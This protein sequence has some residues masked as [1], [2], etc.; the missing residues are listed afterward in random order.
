MSAFFISIYRLFHN[1]KLLFYS[2]LFIFLGLMAF[3]ASR[4]RFEEDITKTMGKADD[5]DSTAFV[6]RNLKMADKL[7]IEVAF[8]D[9]AASPGPLKLIDHAT[10]LVDSLNRYFDSTIIKNILFQASENDILATMQ[11]V[12][13]H[14]PSFLNEKDYLKIDS[15]L[16]P[17]AINEAFAGN[18]RILTTPASMVLRSRIQQDPLGITS[19]AL[20]K[21]RS[22]QA[23][24]SYRIIDGCIFSQDLRH[25]LLFVVPACPSSETSKNTLLIAGIDKIIRSFPSPEE[26]GISIGYF[27]AAA[28]SV[29][30]ANQL[31]KD[32]AL[33]LTLS[34]LLIFMLVGWYFKSFRIPLLGFLPAI[35]GAVLALALL[36]LVKGYISAISLGIGS[37][38]LGLI[39]DYTLYL[40]N[41]YKKSG[42]IELML[43][44]LSLS[45]VLCSLTTAGAFLCLIFLNS[46][47]LHDLGWFA[48]ISVSGAAFFSLIIL[49]HF[50]GKPSRERT[51]TRNLNW[52]DRLG[53]FPFERTRILILI[54]VL[55][56]A[57]SLF[58]TGKVE[59]ETDM[60]ALSFTTP[61]LKKIEADLDRIGNYKLK[62]TFLVAHAG[63]AEKALRIRENLR[64]KLHESQSKGLVKGISDGGVLLQS[65]SIQWLKIARWNSFWTTERKTQLRQ[66]IHSVSNQYGFRPEAFNVFFELIEKPYQPLSA[67][68]KKLTTN[69]LI[70]DWITLLPGKALVPVILKSTEKDKQQVYNFL[71]KE[72]GVVVFDKQ[73]LAARF[74]ESVK[75]DFDLLVKLSM[76]FVTLLLVVSLG[77]IELGL[78]TALPMFISWFI[79]LGFMGMTGISFNI[80]NIIISSFIFGLGVDYSILML[81]TLQQSYVTGKQ[82]LATTKVSILLSALTTL[83][84]VGALFFARHPALHSIALISMVGMFVVVMVTFIMVPLIFN[85][86]IFNRSFKGTFPVTLRI[87]IKT[88]VTWGNIVL[89][90][91]I[92]MVMGVLIK[93]LVP[94]GKAQKEKY[95]HRLF[96]RL[97][98]WYIAV[99]FPRHHLL[100]NEGGEDFTRPAIII[101][102]HQSLIETPAFLRLH[103]KILILTSNWVYKSP[104]FGPI[105]RLAGFF[106]V[107]LGVENL[108]EPLRAKIREGYSLLIFPEGHRSADQQI[109]R[110]HRG[111]F[112]LAEKL[113]IDLLPVVVFGSGDF[114][115]KGDFWGRPNSLYMKIMPR[116][117][118]DDPVYGSTYPERA[119]KIRQVYINWY[120]S[121]KSLYGNAHYYRQKLILNY[122][123]KGPV[124]EW[125]LRTKLH[126]EE[127]YEI[128]NRLMPRKGNILDLGCGYGYI[129]YMLM[130]TSDERKLTGVDYDAEKIRLASG[131]F[132]KNDRIHF[133]CKDVTTMEINPHDGFLLGDLLHY[134]SPENQDALLRKCCSNLRP[135]GVIMIRDADS[136]LEKRH[137]RSV[138]TEFFSTHSGFNKTMDDS[139]TLYF[140]SAG[141]IQ[142]V[143]ESFGMTMEI[144]DNKKVTS[145]NLFVIR[146]G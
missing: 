7:V 100:I 114:L 6:I 117:A 104:V 96:S 29:S 130:L 70:T 22:L 4:I 67:T 61:E 72:P 13:D 138:L 135:G 49:P 94:T 140:T 12:I 9:S 88:L 11:L 136:G 62:N 47:V 35:F 34:F 97:T 120:T 122:V 26:S 3:F 10:Q 133:L 51:K 53:N 112:Y 113:Q 17:Q 116:I 24:S 105:A 59:F 127:N 38:I 99:T 68:D 83:F 107:D 93:Y 89:I 109:K 2:I 69:P 65:D 16:T 87:F 19:P 143:V 102:N 101:S 33:T 131:C 90:A 57:I 14:L 81:R 85:K 52:I 54:P 110:F 45:I 50:L 75:S 27:G 78:L 146:L 137:Q 77:R 124:L 79:T 121:L 39:V 129:S 106:N 115:A 128:F 144:I 40:V 134:L 123:L 71:G 48:A 111:A 41:H 25:L 42:D 139:G 37:I 63:S 18:R 58:F 125:Y 1:H 32:I 82:E 21:L 142:K 95:F 145:N 8:S 103:P 118:W 132:S 55:L 76:G 126:L 23:D 141:N 5:P 44:D 92:M 108:V 91:L 74:V 80:F 15:L 30:N 86:L 98:Q 56:L 43:K 60:N 31:K 73:Q 20:V 36:S 64:G 119:R 66:R 28:V 84:G 46:G